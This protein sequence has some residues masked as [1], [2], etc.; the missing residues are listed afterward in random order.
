MA[1]FA[2]S[3]PGRRPKA[4]RRVGGPPAPAR[5]R[6]VSVL[7]LI[8]L[9]LVTGC[10]PG[11]PPTAA[12]G[13]LDL[14][15]WRFAEDGP[16]ELDGEWAFYRGR[17]IPP[18]GSTSVPAGYLEVPSYWDDALGEGA[19]E[20]STGYASYVLE[21]TLPPERPPLALKLLDMGTAYELFVN[22][23]PVAS[24][25]RVGRTAEQTAP[26]YD[27]KV[28]V[29][30]PVEGDELRIVVRIAN[31]AYRTGGFWE[32]ITLGGVEDV[33]DLRERA[34]FLELLV[35]GAIAIMG[36]YHLGVYAARRED[37]SPLYFGVFC[38]AIVAR[39]FTT[40]ERV[41]TDM[42]PGLDWLI[43]IHVVFLSFLVAAL[44]FAAFVAALYPQAMLRWPLRLLYGVG[45]LMI[46]VV[47]LTPPSIF[48]P[49]LRL[50]QLYLVLA[51]AYGLYT[52][53]VAVR[54]RLPG[55]GLF[56]IGFLGIV[57]GV[58]NDVARSVWVLDTSANLIGPGLLFFIFAQAGLLS[59][60]F[61]D[62]FERE[63][64][65]SAQLT[66]YTRTLEERVRQ[67]T[68]AL[69]R[70]NRQ[71]AEVNDQLEEMATTDAL[72]G[73]ANRRRFDDLLDQ[74]WAR[75]RRRGAPL[76]LLLVDADS[77]KEYNDLYGHTAGDQALEA[78][79]KALEDA[80]RRATDMVARYGGE[81][82]AI[83]LPDTER[84]G[85]AQIAESIRK[86]VRAVG[87][88]HR[89]SAVGELTVSVGVA[90]MV[91]SGPHEAGAL[92]DAADAALYRA[93]ER[94]RN[95]VVVSG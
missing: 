38:L 60:R 47:V 68:A 11:D 58:A 45:A 91:P 39:I 89:G 17:L 6:L 88:P 92:V 86:A 33:L 87:I 62:A 51:V 76:A 61:S 24:D 42:A 2:I 66:E 43:L 35:A 36:L 18:G 31:F 72:T 16:V 12:D 13:E 63:E 52:L 85:A 79:A 78:A 69:E 4:P 19:A 22:G 3:T 50:Y 48:S 80:V 9:A 5:R 10:T 73:V 95:R 21:L 25:G 54:D 29:L 14:S 55:A 57:V 32:S 53:F 82:F 93:K 26:E 15:S 81:E 49:L 37:A 64:R 67:R 7:G 71:L 70:A 75:H 27:P 44:S 30:P 84:E 83:L 77:F 28:V 65:L 94:G 59:R 20:Q 56:L 46:A 34:L 23:H 8:G 40:G 74:E 1:Q 90:V 41:L